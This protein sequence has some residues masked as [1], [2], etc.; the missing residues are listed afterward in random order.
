MRT[1]RPPPAKRTWRGRRVLNRPANHRKQQVSRDSTICRNASLGTE[2]KP[3][4]SVPYFFGASLISPNLKALSS[5]MRS[6]CQ[7]TKPRSGASISFQYVRAITRITADL[8]WLGISWDAFG[9]PGDYQGAMEHLKRIGRLYPCFES[10]TELRAR[11]EHRIRRGQSAV[12]DRAMLKLTPEQRASAEAGGKLPHWRFRLSN[13]VVAWTDAIAGPLEARLP[14]ISDPILVAADGT[15]AAAVSR[16]DEY[17]GQGGADDA[18]VSAVDSGG[19]WAYG[20]HREPGG[21]ENPGRPR[22]LACAR[23]CWPQAANAISKGFSPK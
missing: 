5:P 21:A 18:A 4:P 14:A 12:Y 3:S 13:R 22:R 17:A 10:E 16:A 19:A 7:P 20:A 8:R 2:L 23:M 6:T 11:R 1:S 15:P 9:E